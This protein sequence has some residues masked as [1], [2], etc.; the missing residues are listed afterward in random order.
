MFLLGIFLYFY[1]FSTDG[2]LGG[3]AANGF[4]FTNGSVPYLQGFGL[5]GN[6]TL[7][8][9]AG[10]I[11]LGGAAGKSAQFPLHV[12]LPD[13]M[14]GPTTVSALI[15]AATMV[16]A[17]VY[18]LAVSSLFL[19]FTSSDRARDRRDRGVHR[20]LRGDDGR[21]A[22]RHQ[23]GDRVLHDQPARLHGHGRRRR[24][25]DG[26]ALPSVRARVFQGPPVPRGR[27]GHPRR[28]HPGPVQ[29]GRR[30]ENRCA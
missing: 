4:L 18:L 10:T 1:N 27:L 8:T 22:P 6:S 7:L 20:L 14:E 25:R 5:G 2:R 26:G 24:V 11:I 15:H 16:A 9:V 28:R 3:W 17:G 29:D 12:W 30:S 19:G 21:R 13:A 23:A